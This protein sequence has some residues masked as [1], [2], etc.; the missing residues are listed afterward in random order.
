MLN[1]IFWNLVLSG[2]V[3]KIVYPRTLIFL[4]VIYTQWFFISLRIKNP[5]KTTVYARY[6]RKWWLHYLGVFLTVSTPIQGFFF[7]VVYILPQQLLLLITHWR[8]VHLNTA[9]SI[10]FDRNLTCWASYQAIFHFLSITFTT[11]KMKFFIKG[12]CGFAHIYWRN[13]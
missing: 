11:Q 13:P 1:S 10:I 9:F 5:N 3:C 2:K 7:L 4:N 12:F 8:L 6:R